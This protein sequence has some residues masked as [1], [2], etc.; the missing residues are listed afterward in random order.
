MRP[1]DEH[2]SGVGMVRLA[3]GPPS[4]RCTFANDISETKGRVYRANFGG[5]ELNP[6]AVWLFLVLIA[7]V[8]A[9][10]RAPSPIVLENVCGLITSKG[11]ADLAA[12]CAALQGLGYFVGAVVIDASNFLPRSRPRIF[13]IAVRNDIEIPDRL[14][15]DGPT[16]NYAAGSLRRIVASFSSELAASWVWWRLPP[17]PRTICLRLSEQFSADAARRTRRARSRR[18][19]R[20]QPRICACAAVQ[21]RP[22]RGGSGGDGRGSAQALG[23]DRRGTPT[24]RGGGGAEA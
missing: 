7:G 18:S 4:W 1:Y 17:P 13:I 6:G 16:D 2:S 9:E 23:S 20:A 3:L 5:A 21:C 19:D 22:P 8:K 11:G 15:G 14:Q 24:T 12:I 10:G